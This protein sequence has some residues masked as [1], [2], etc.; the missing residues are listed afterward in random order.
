VNGEPP[1]RRRLLREAA[2]LVLLWAAYSVG[3]WVAAQHAGNAFV[4]ADEV[5][6][7]ERGL[8]MPNE[9]HLQAW[10]LHW[11]AAVRATNSYYAWV[12]FPATVSCLA[13]LFIRYPRH[14]LWIRRVLGSVTAAALVVHL[15]YPLAP[16][17]MMPQ[18]GFV[19]TGVRF[20]QSVYGPVSGSDGLANQF[21]AMP[22]LH[23][24]W[25][26]AVALALAAV[27]SGRLRLLWFVHPAATFL[28][29]VVTANH[30]W[31]DGVV[32]AVLVAVAVA[33]QPWP[34]VDASE[35]LDAPTDRGSQVRS[36]G[37]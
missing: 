11:P 33:V 19:D 12:H 35:D 8:Q 4:H 34:G 36:A 10:L 37:V 17:R 20:G 7:L 9:A 31:L 30:F 1:L 25:A 21:A 32:S 27:T 24:G 28:V 18:H 29:V 22:S 5:W 15:L 2:L 16:P 6:S 26:F 23:V 14:Y 13:W 3:R